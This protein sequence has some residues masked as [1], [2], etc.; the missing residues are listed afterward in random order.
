MRKK[1]L[2][3]ILHSSPPVHGASKVGDFIRASQKVC[4][5]FECKYIK[6]D[7]SNSLSDI[8][9]VNMKK[10]ILSIELFIKV[11]FFM[12]SFRPDKIYFTSSVRGVAFYRDLLLSLI[13]KTYRV[14]FKCDVF[15]HYHT[16][17]VGD[18]TKKKLNLLMT[19]FF[20]HDC[21]LILLSNFL[22]S[23]F[24][25]VE[26]YRKVFFLPNGVSS[27]Y[28]QNDFENYISNKDYESIN[29]LY[30]SNMI[31]EKG[32]FEVLKL[33][34]KFKGTNVKFNFA[35]SWTNTNDEQEFFS[36]IN[37]HELEDMVHFHGFIGGEEKISLFEKSHVFVFPTRYRNEA[38]PLCVLEAFSFG[39]P[40]LV[41]DE[42]SL[43][44]MVGHRNGAVISDM[45]E[46]EKTLK[47]LLDTHVNVETA[48]TCRATFDNYFT[49][50]KFE[51][52]LLEILK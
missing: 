35:G 28:N 5:E 4:D 1:K 49:L 40:V 48:L 42:A 11:A 39:L 9:R 34:R 23:E 18:F 24:K 8:G 51:S 33:A 30:L 27:N 50:D 52:N 38:F 46:L 16:K 37:E 47:N 44:S 2:L 15:Y 19:R 41:T 45:T 26:T 14:F 31:K 7:S 32:Y 21:Y 10:I 17:G 22:E 13:W 12:F 25:N 20:L 43:P 36:Y 6:I 29:I 3:L